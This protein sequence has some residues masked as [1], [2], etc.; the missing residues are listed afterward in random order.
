MFNDLKV[1]HVGIV[2]N[3]DAMSSI[4]KNSGNV[5]IEDKIQGVWVCFVWDDSLKLYKEY[6]TRE[7]RVKNAKIGFN[8]VCYDINSQTEMDTLHNILI[9]NR[10][11]IRLTLPEP[12]PTKQCNIVTFYKIIGLGIVE[13]NIINRDA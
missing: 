3:R 2:V 10:L 11:G 12:S 6:I 7:G 4:E 13:F 1:N 9:K 8:H 5:F